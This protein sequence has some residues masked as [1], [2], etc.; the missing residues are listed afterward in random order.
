MSRFRL[1]RETDKIKVK[2]PDKSVW[3]GFW[4]GLKPFFL[5]LLEKKEIYR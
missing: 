2:S 1:G 3:I 5:D 4:G